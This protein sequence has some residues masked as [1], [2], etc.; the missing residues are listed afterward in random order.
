MRVASAKKCRKSLIF[1]AIKAGSKTKRANN[2]KRT[3]L[4]IALA[5]ARRMDLVMPSAML[6]EIHEAR[7]KLIQTQQHI[8]LLN[9]VSILINHCQ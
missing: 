8:R 2:K 1:C 9:R 5:G 7:R 3:A 4:F 6:Q